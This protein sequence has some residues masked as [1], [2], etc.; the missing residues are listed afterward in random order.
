MTSA[1]SDET[2]VLF[3]YLGNFGV[4]AARAAGHP[5]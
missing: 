4:S 1:A 2:P 3:D 5:A